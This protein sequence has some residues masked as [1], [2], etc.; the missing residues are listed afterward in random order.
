M[1][2]IGFRSFCLDSTCCMDVIRGNI[3]QC[4]STISLIDLISNQ[5]FSA[6]QLIMQPTM[7]LWQAP[8]MSVLRTRTPFNSIHLNNTF[9]VWHTFWISQFSPFSAISKSSMTT[10]IPLLTT[11]IWATTG[12]QIP[13]GILRSL[14]SKF[15]K[16]PRYDSCYVRTC[17][18]RA[19]KSL[20]T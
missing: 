4:T 16:L 17:L 18:P 1:P 12:S 13:K 7:T 8:W 6:S 3:C 5:S 20:L 14:C 10:P 11:R 19:T 15:A 9:H 2:S